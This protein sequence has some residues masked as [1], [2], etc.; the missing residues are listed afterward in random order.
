MNN[1]L[2]IK[3]ELKKIL[4]SKNVDFQRFF[5]LSH[6]FIEYDESNL[7]FRTDSGTISHL[8]KD[9][10][11][12]HTTAIIELVKNGYDA[13]ATKVEI[14]IITKQNNPYIRVADN[15][16]G[17][18]N[19]DIINKWL[20]IGYSDKRINKKTT[21]NRRKTGEKGI[22]RLSADRLGSEI[23]LKTKQIN[24]KIIGI[25]IDWDD[26]TKQRTDLSLIPLKKVE[27]STIRLPKDNLKNNHGTEIV[28]TNLRNQ[29]RDSDAKKLFE[30]LSLLVSPF[31][32]KSDFN[33]NLITDI[34]TEY[35]GEIKVKEHLEPEVSIQVIYEG[36]DDEITYTLKDKYKFS[37]EE[38][39][40]ISWTQL[41]QKN[42]IDGKKYLK[43]IKNISVSKESP[44]CG[45][46][47]IDLMFY[48]IEGAFVE[49]TEFTLKKL[50]EYLSYNGGIKIY[51]DDISLKPYGFTGCEGEDWLDLGER[52]GRDPAGIGR[53]GWKVKNNQMMGAVYIQRDDNPNLDDSAARE[54]LVHNEAYHDLRA[55]TLC[56]IRLLELHRFN[57]KKKL[58]KKD[59]K[60]R[61]SNRALLEEYKKE[62]D[63]LK[64][65]LKEL[66]AIAI[67]NKHD[68]VL[69]ASEQVQIVVD[70]TKETEEA[71]ED[72]L[73][74]NRTLSG[75]A[76]LGISSAVFGHE[77]RISVDKLNIVIGNILLLIQ[78]KQFD[79]K[80]TI[81][82]IE[83]A[84][85]YANQVH[86]W[87]S[88]A[89]S[90]IKR[91]KRRKH[92]INIEKIIDNIIKDIKP[93]FE[94]REIKIEPIMTEVIAKT[95]P[96]DIETIVLNLM[97]NSYSAC[98]AN[99]TGRIVQVELKETQRDGH[100]GFSIC[101]ADSGHGVDEKLREII[102]EALFTTKT[103]EQGKETGTGLG[104][105][106][107][108]SLV[109]DLKGDCYVENDP[110]LKG[111]R[112]SIWLPST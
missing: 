91:D 97:T 64:S 9:S 47:M 76:T 71:I 108:K 12:D 80:R 105:T 2:K 11:K 67:Q 68:Y 100:N 48:P 32:T 21:T 61:K 60:K 1:E 58:H 20:R 83:E 15:G 42:N 7:R 92:K 66:K 10:I 3:N 33:I 55:L 41:T 30:E 111:A 4:E 102:W 34:E 36:V 26:F 35:K 103:G 45:P 17:M 8:G 40:R 73:N 110:T 72:I 107:V 18:S 90:R 99:P 78:S 101:V 84:Q 70:K 49:G 29:W 37:Q 88:F 39:N 77:T 104:L 14:E 16:T 93:I 56:C 31:R 95:F 85:K 51:R 75:L 27:S 89:L 63:N 6:D 38:E 57:I 109:E 25:I 59:E 82:R 94:A 112:F 28:I 13:D 74:K 62:L 43:D 44:S 79:L 69:S 53:E 98:L 22:G 86:E 54:G 81:T 50:R 5:E 96:M 24:S 65:E 106:I 19:D 46:V 52:Q 87:G 23:L